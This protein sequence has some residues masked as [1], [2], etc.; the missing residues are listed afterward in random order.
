MPQTANTR[1][2]YLTLYL[3]LCF[4]FYKHG[5][6]F[7]FAF[8]SHV[9]DMFVLLYACGFRA[10]Q[11]NPVYDFVWPKWPKDIGPC[12]CTKCKKAKN[13]QPAF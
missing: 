5:L 10:T 1:A 3:A 8:G 12:D 2:P 4:C 6:A 11:P 9:L 13:R 7:H